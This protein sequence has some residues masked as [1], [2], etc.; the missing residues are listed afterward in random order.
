MGHLQASGLPELEACRRRGWPYRWR[1]RGR[2]VG[3]ERLRPDTVLF[4]K[5]W[6]TARKE[7]DRFMGAPMAVVCKADNHN[8]AGN[9][10]HGP[11]SQS[12]PGP[13]TTPWL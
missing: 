3:R 1:A 13:D 9:Y 10:L 5:Q 4:T 11:K 12:L 2:A 6:T 8:Q 7:I